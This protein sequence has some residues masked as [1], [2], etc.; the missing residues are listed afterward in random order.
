MPPPQLIFLIKKVK[1]KSAKPEISLA[2]KRPKTERYWT[3]LTL[4]KM[5]LHRNVLVKMNT[6]KNNT[7]QK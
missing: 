4:V 3:E 6:D 2:M 1:T 7:R 5:T